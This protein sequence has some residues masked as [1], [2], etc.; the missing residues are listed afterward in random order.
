VG[1]N[2]IFYSFFSL[3]FVLY[4]FSCFFFLSNLFYNIIF[5][6]HIS[7]SFNHTII[8]I[9][10]ITG[11]RITIPVPNVSTK[12]LNTK[13]NTIPPSIRYNRDIRNPHI[14]GSAIIII[15]IISTTIA[16][17][18]M[19]SYPLQIPAIMPKDTTNTLII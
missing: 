18:I 19:V 10:S 6:L 17:N 3:I 1:E 14:V 2:L 16:Q 5:F 13:K 9:T 4:I 12:N 15:A 8:K 7:F 11:R